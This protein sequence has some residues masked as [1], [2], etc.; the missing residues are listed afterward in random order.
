MKAE[1]ERGGRDLRKTQRRE[2][3]D[4]PNET[5]LGDF[6]FPFDFTFRLAGLGGGQDRTRERVRK[7][8]GKGGSRSILAS[9]LSEKRRRVG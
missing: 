6:R 3:R 1:R 4:T 7:E 2:K 8:R 5:A 9:V